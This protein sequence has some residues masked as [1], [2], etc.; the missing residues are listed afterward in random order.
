MMKVYKQTLPQLGGYLCHG[1]K[2]DLARV[3]RFIAQVGVTGVLPFGLSACWDQQVC[4]AKAGLPCSACASACWGLLRVA[5]LL[6]CRVRLVTRSSMP[7]PLLLQVGR[8]EDAIFSKRMRL[9]QRCVVGGVLWG[10]GYWHGRGGEQHSAKIRALSCGCR[11]L[12]QKRLCPTVV[13]IGASAA[14]LLAGFLQ[15]ASCSGAAAACY[16]S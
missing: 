4:T 8:F 5:L 13:G 14:A 9:L 6:H 15:C 7:L 16:S 10:M 1:A 2:V 3:E 12:R 11:Q